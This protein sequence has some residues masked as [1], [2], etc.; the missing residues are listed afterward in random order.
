[1]INYGLQLETQWRL[2]NWKHSQVS[3]YGSLCVVKK[4]CRLNKSA[5]RGKFSI[6]TILIVSYFQ[7]FKICIP[8][9]KFLTW[10]PENEGLTVS[11][12][13]LHGVQHMYIK[14]QLI[15]F[16]VLLVTPTQINTSSYRD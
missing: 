12:I 13:I 8:S 10:R 4:K 2:I 6:K 3:C 1:M 16:I 15:Q 7:V 14:F 11:S 5:A 9:N